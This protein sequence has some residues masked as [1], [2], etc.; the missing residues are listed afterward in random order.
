MASVA[1]KW[2][3]TDSTAPPK[4][5]VEEIITGERLQ[6][7]ADISV[8]TAQKARF[9]SSCPVMP[10][11]IFPPHLDP[12]T[13][14]VALRESHVVFVYA[15]LINDFLERVLPLLHRPIVLITHNADTNIGERYR[16]AL[17][18]PLIIHWYAQNADLNHPKL[19]PLPIGI[20]N[21]QWPHGD[22]A[23]LGSKMGQARLMTSGLYVNFNVSTN[24]KVRGP[25]LNALRTK[26]F[27][28]MRRQNR[29]FQAIS[30]R[31]LDLCGIHYVRN[32]RPKPYAAYISEFAQWR[33]CISPP[34]NGID[35]HRTW[36][37]LYLGVIPVLIPPAGRVLAHLP[38]ILVKDLDSLTLQDLESA[39]ADLNGPFAWEQLTLSY[40]RERITSHGKQ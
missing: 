21:S 33:F 24:L 12:P 37:A 4:I 17:E 1:G 6:A 7:I 36:E 38:H 18:N 8:T 5:P 31:L 22:I 16:L 2:L 40:W 35:C 19:T 26:S 15:D 9:H 11:A 23:V 30:R 25:L 34:G 20:A 27:T 39:R 10:L 32:E 29:L 28:N 3:A 13:G 14:V